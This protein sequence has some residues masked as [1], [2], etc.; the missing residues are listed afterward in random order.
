MSSRT[1]LR[2]RDAEECR[3]G[4]AQIAVVLVGLL[5]CMTALSL[6]NVAEADIV[7]EW[8]FQEQGDVEAGRFLTDGDLIGN[9]APAAT[10]NVLDFE[11]THSRVCPVQLRTRAGCERG[12]RPNERHPS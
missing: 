1:G 5:T 8:S 4:V 3:C 6:A 2:T 9:A 12:H 7:W 11:V 10:Y